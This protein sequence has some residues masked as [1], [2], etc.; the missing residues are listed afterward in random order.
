MSFTRWIFQPLNEHPALFIV[1][2]WGAAVLNG[3]VGWMR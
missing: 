1:G 3:I 2:I